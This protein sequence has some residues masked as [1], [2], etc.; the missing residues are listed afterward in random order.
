M[1]KNGNINDEVYRSIRYSHSIILANVATAII[2]L[3]VS[4]KVSAL[5]ELKGHIQIP[6]S[7]MKK[8]V[9]KFNAK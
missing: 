7:W 8:A 3:N 6:Q 5:V 1:Q 9:N 4:H 2:A